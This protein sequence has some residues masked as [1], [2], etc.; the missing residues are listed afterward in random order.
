ML[1]APVSRSAIVI[2]KCRES[3]FSRRPGGC[4]IQSDSDPDR[5]R[6]TPAAVL[7]AYC[8]RR[9]DG[10]LDNADTGIHGTDADAR[11]AAVLPVRRAFPLRSL[12]ARLSVLTRID[13]IAY[14]V[15]RCGTQ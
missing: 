10:G 11:Y 14:A 2:G 8:V 12:P 13:P 4:A 3:L 6:R 7:R 1:V 5:N 15:T 9:N